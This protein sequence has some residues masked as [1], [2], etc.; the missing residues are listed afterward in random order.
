MKIKVFA[1]ELLGI[2]IFLKIY[3]LKKEEEEEKLIFSVK[4][5]YFTSER[6]VFGEISCRSSP[7]HATR[8]LHQ[9]V[10]KFESKPSSLNR[11]V[12]QVLLHKLI[13][14]LFILTKTCF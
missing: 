12:P 9:Y 13:E 4:K 14:Y 7:C 10:L 1:A 6:Q 8:I 2:I 5:T 3:L 11:V